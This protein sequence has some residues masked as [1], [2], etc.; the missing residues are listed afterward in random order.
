MVLWD[1]KQIN[2]TELGKYLFLDSGTLT[3]VLKKLERKGYIERNRSKEDERNLIVSITD[4]GV[5]L[6]NEVRDIPSNIAKCVN[7]EP[8]ESTQ[9]YI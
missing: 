3:P 1:K 5:Q 8:K 2:V 9:L 6:K 7:L 4:L